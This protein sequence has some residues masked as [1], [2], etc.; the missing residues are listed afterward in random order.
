MN[1]GF[2]RAQFIPLL[3]CMLL[4]PVVITGQENSIYTLQSNEEFVY[5]SFGLNDDGSQSYTFT[6]VRTP[7][8]GKTVYRRELDAYAGV[9]PMISGGAM[10]VDQDVQDYDEFDYYI[11]FNGN[12][13]GPYDRFHDISMED[14]NVEN[15]ITPDGEGL[16]FAAVRGQRYNLIINSRMH[17]SYWSHTQAP[18]VAEAPG[19]YAY[20]MQFDRNDW[21]LREVYDRVHQGFARFWNLEYSADGSRLLY[22]GAPN[23]LNERY[24]YINHERVAGPYTSVLPY[25]TGFAGDSNTPYFL[26]H[27]AEGVELTVGSQRVHLPSGVR[28]IGRIFYTNGQL[29]FSGQVDGQQ[30]V[31]L[32]TISTSELVQRE[33]RLGG[34]GILESTTQSYFSI[35]DWD[36]NH[37]LIDASNNTVSSIPQSDLGDSTSTVVYRVCPNDNIYAYY[38]G[39]ILRN[40]QPYEPAGTDFYRIIHFSFNPFTGE[41]QIAVNL[42][43]ELHT[44]R[45]RIIYDGRA[46][47]ITGDMDNFER[48]SYFSP[49]GPFYWIKRNIHGTSDWRWQIYRDNKRLT[50]E[51][52]SIV[53]LTVSDDGSR[54]AALVSRDPDVNIFHYASTNRIMHSDLDLLVDGQIIDGNFSAPV[55]SQQ[56][57]GFLVMAQDGRDVIIRQ[58]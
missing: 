32:Y 40:G 35:I 34:G 1:R 23:R 44:N 57:G 33:G 46:L 20:A 48:Y 15:W 56:A 14:P 47:D 8:P 50:E 52:H 58:F 38:Q 27:T 9:E 55:W 18:I 37:I 24:V 12:R 11:I 5:G 30:Y 2:V 21:R 13:L 49:E 36:N 26:G 6:V 41:P 17:I 25:V 3:V 51:F 42:E 29:A 16:T 7:A 54:Y 19:T 28:N 31:F 4:V 45:R 53:E 22:V 43:P 10:R 39:T